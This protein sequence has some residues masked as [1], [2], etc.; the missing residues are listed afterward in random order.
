MKKIKQQK[1]MQ[2]ILVEVPAAL[3]SATKTRYLR[4]GVSQQLAIRHKR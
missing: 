1:E 2:L 4:Q 3:G